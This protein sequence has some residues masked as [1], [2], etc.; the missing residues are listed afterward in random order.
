MRCDVKFCRGCE[1]SKRIQKKLYSINLSWDFPA[2]RLLFIFSKMHQNRYA[3]EIIKHHK[4]SLHDKFD[5]LTTYNLTLR[6]A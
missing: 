4:N 2:F 1:T 5:T 3:Y 6:G